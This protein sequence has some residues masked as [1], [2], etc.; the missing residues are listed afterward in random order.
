MEKSGKC[1]AIQDTIIVMYLSISHITYGRIY[2]RHIRKESDQA[3]SFLWNLLVFLFLFL[4]YF[5]VTLLHWNDSIPV[6][7]V[8]SQFYHDLSQFYY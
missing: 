5:P 8:F 3:V 7:G 1:H 6:S 2:I 4:S